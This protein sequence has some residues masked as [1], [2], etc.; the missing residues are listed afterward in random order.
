MMKEKTREILDS[1]VGAWIA[2]LIIIGALTLIGWGGKYWMDMNYVS[3]IDMV[4]AHE[5]MLITFTNSVQAH[6]DQDVHMPYLQKIKE[7][8][9]R[10]EHET[11]KRESEHDDDIIRQEIREGFREFREAQDRRFDQLASMIQSN[12]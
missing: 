2:R 10:A 12:N 1:P 8:P 3:K 4:V 7:F 5:N 11:L 6:L 9:T